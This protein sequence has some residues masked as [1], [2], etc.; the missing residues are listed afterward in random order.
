M[1]FC[2]KCGARLNEGA[3]FCSNCGAPQEVSAQ[4]AWT[5]S[6]QQG[7]PP[8][9]QTWPNE[10]QFHPQ[11]IESNKVMAI[12]AYFGIL[13]LIPL[14][15]AKESKFARYHVN[16][17]L[18]LFIAEVAYG[19]VYAILSSIIWAISWRLYFITRIIGI[20]SL[21]FLVLSVIGIVNAVNGQ[22][23]E[24]PVIGKFKILK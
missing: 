9:Q 17:G 14:F 18:V 5:S 21:V 13:V 22:A 24:L 2:S 10:Q 4:Q 20:F 23:K 11:D 15:A 6:E 8:G 19:I 7:W 1:S 12:L 16:Q 3:T